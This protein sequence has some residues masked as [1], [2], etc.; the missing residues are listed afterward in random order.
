M[1]RRITDFLRYTRAKHKSRRSNRVVRP[2]CYRVARGLVIISSVFFFLNY[3]HIYQS[4]HYPDTFAQKGNAALV[5]NCNTFTYVIIR[6][7]AGQ[8]D[9]VIDAM[10]TRVG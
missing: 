1:T 6:I 5:I 2:Y 7:S 8:N 10:R 9:G 3:P 4:D